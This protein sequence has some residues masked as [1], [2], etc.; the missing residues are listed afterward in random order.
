MDKTSHLLSDAGSRIS[1]SRSLKYYSANIIIELAV[2]SFVPANG[3]GRFPCAHALNS[4]HAQCVK[5]RR[6]GRNPARH[7]SSHCPAAVSIFC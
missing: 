2:R 6:S 1:D 4:G 3:E 5:P 7:T